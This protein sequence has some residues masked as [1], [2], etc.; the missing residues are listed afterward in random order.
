MRR[1]KIENIAS[2]CCSCYGLKEEKCLEEL[3][4]LVA[5]HCPKEYLIFA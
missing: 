5:K 2:N 1:N 3:Q 4:Q